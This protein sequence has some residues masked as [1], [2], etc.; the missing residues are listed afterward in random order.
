M[1]CWQIPRLSLKHGVVTFGIIQFSARFHLVSHPEALPPS[2]DIEAIISGRKRARFLHVVG[3]P[4]TIRS[5]EFTTSEN[6]LSD[7]NG[8]FVNV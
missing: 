1:A 8:V 5:E 7:G 3:D 6:S 4:W 2:D